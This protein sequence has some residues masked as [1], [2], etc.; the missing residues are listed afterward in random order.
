MESSLV[1]P[2]RVVLI[3]AGKYGYAEVDLTRPLHIVGPNNVGKTTL[4]NALQFLYVDDRRHMDFGERTS[5]ETL[6]YYFRSTESYLLFECLTPTGYKVVGF[7][8]LGPVRQYGYDR[9]AYTGRYAQEDFVEEG[10]VRTADDVYRALAVRG[11]RKLEPKHLRAALTGLGDDLGVGL[12]LLPLRNADDYP[13]FKTVFGH[14][15]RLSHLKQHELKELLCEVYRATFPQVEVRL[16]DAI[17]E[18]FASVQRQV[19]RV[20]ELE[21]LRPTIERV[22]RK[23]ERRTALRIALPAERRA[24]LAEGE[25]LLAHLEATRERH[26]DCEE[27]LREDAVAVRSVAE[28]GQMELATLNRQEGG[29]QERIQQHEARRAALEGFDVAAAR[30]ERG[31]L[32]RER[33]RLVQTL[34][35]NENPA[36]LRAQLADAERAL[37]D[38]RARLDRL[39]EAAGV[40]LQ[41]HFDRDE[42]DILFRLLH[43]ALLGLPVDGDDLRVHDA[44]E[45]VEHLR[46]LLTHRQEAWFAFGG[47]E[48]RLEALPAAPLDEYLSA[49][50]LTARIAE[51]Q[52]LVDDLCTRLEAAER[53]AALEAER[54]ALTERLQALGQRLHEAERLAAEA[55]E[56]ARWSADLTQLR[57]RVA[58][59][60]DHVRQA[61]ERRIELD[62]ALREHTDAA[63]RT[64][65]RIDEV[66]TQLRS[67]PPLAWDAPADAPP[68]STEPVPAEQDFGTLVERYGQR[69]AE[70][71]ALA[72]D[73]ADALAEIEQRSY[74]SY[75]SGDEEELLR[76]LAEQVQALP[77]Q[78]EVLDAA[79]QSLASSLQRGFRDLV[80][81]LDVLKGH[82]AALNRVLATASVS[83]LR[84]LRL[85]VEPN[86]SLVGMLRAVVEHETAP[87]LSDPAARAGALQRVSEL[88]QKHPVIHL[89]DL[90]S[91]AFEVERADGQVERYPDLDRIESNGTSITI[92]VLTNLVL[93]KGLFRERQAKQLPFYLDEAS[94]LDEENLRAIVRQAQAFGFVPVLASPA[95]S[96]AAEHLY[97]PQEVQGRVY[98]RPSHHL[99]RLQRTR[100]DEVT[101]EPTDPADDVAKAT[102]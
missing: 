13:R 69:L 58:E 33:D 101:L 91:V 61:S 29:L 75:G 85:L 72:R 71:D 48:V 15:L 53:G 96:E 2:T 93:L 38:R 6:R 12:G 60:E 68:P 22:L 34:G 98:I 14:L 3:N 92:K 43:P 100:A 30:S 79:W 82:V 8:G 50:A 83:D 24:V 16:G 1:G 25:R 41:E 10:H 47:A 80:Q 54:K 78:R 88:L 70:H 28:H 40:R 44:S 59:V 26:R 45:V 20:E 97:F 90:F 65:R 55:A 35:R 32:E 23:A 74:G 7:R 99:V 51:G 64:G 67:L 5:A 86:Q 73:I 56:A 37:E 89:R 39:A 76:R 66:A 42:L 9:F 57:A 62:R 36:R 49:D 31:H 95:P 102:A 46:T 11:F 17:A 4:V 87:L 52:A 63:A 77:K 21:T 19:Q 94:S 81:S 27:A 84:R 18:D